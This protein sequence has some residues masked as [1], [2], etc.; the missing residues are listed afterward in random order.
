MNRELIK[1]GHAFPFP[2]F[3]DGRRVTTELYVNVYGV[4]IYRMVVWMTQE[5][6]NDW[7]KRDY[8]GGQ[9]IHEIVE[10]DDI[11]ALREMAQWTEKKHRARSLC[12]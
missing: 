3:I 6:V 12:Y 5:E 10:T 11:W 1:S 8:P 7:G 2:N 9:F 4:N